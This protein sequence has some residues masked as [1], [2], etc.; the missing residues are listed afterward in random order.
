[1]R[2]ENPRTYLHAKVTAYAN[3]RE[4]EKVAAETARASQEA[5]VKRQE[6]A[7]QEYRDSD[8]HPGTHPIPY[9]DWPGIVKQ[10]QAHLRKAL[11]HDPKAL[12]EKNCVDALA[13]IAKGESGLLSHICIMGPA[14]AANAK[15]REL[16]DQIA[17]ARAD[18]AQADKFLRT[19][20]NS[21]SASPHALLWGPPENAKLTYDA[22][23][24][25]FLIQAQPA[26]AAA[27]RKL[28]SRDA[29]PAPPK[30][31]ATLTAEK[32][33]EW[34]ATLKEAKN[35]PEFS[36]LGTRY[37]SAKIMKEAF[38]ACPLPKED[39]LVTSIQT[40]ADGIHSAEVARE[41]NPIERAKVAKWASLRRR[42][43]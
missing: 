32:C 7:Y 27:A 17:K 33:A 39:P 42:V 22:E 19:S 14:G 36:A 24:G 31:P 12:A 30:D 2:E 4:K 43:Q 18:I 1:M 38:S 21:L 37:E 9:K 41:S 29:H 28:C 20:L 5:I 3:A 40:L 34:N 35:F 10:R 6:K 15:I 26:A 8:P 16:N 11:A 23:Q 25:S 13:S